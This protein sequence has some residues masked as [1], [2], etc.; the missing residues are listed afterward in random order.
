MGTLPE[1]L[2]V[3]EGNELLLTNLRVSVCALFGIEG[4]E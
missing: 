4:R 2:L 3:L 1:N